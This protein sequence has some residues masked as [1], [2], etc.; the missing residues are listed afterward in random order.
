M[1]TTSAEQLLTWYDTN[2]RD[3]PWRR[4]R[5][6]Y[7]VLVSEIMLQQTRVEAVKGYY[8]RFL[9]ALPTLKSLAEADEDT[10]LKLWE[11]LGYYSRVRNLRRCAAAVRED[12]HGRPPRTAAELATL[13]GIGPYTAAALASIC[14]GEKVPAVDG[15]LL[16]IFARMTGYEEDVLAAR[17][18]KEAAAFF[19][20]LMEDLPEEEPFREAYPNS[21]PARPAGIF[22]M[23]LMDLGA[24]VCLPNTAPL[25]DGCPWR[26]ACAA[27]KAGTQEDL[28]LRLKKQ[29]KTTEERTVFVIRFAG[30][31]VLRKRPDTGLLAGLYEF[32]NTEGHLSQKTAL[33]YVESL[34]FGALRIKR[35]PPAKHVFS[36]R[37]WDMICY[38]VFADEWSDFDRRSPYV[39]A[40]DGVSSEGS[41]G[42]LFLADPATLTDTWSMPAAFAAWRDPLREEG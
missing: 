36:H 8:A 11:G 10:C 37:I 34:G 31:V 33:A 2:R 20:A 27:R 38:E 29:T 30:S 6:F 19:R 13:P 41:S 15:N 18:K 9:K 22:N 12:Y 1:K 24:T 28:P 3:L 14:Y 23:A 42:A 25:C 5:Q 16:R 35:L 26:T 7:H 21:G 39:P 40:T 17:A 4:D 32:P